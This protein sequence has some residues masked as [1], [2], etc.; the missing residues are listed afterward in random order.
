MKHSTT[1]RIANRNWRSVQCL[2]AP[3]RMFSV[4]VTE[5][6]SS[7]AVAQLL[8]A[9]SSAPKNI[10]CANSGTCCRIRLGRISCGSV[11]IRPRTI[12][13]SISVAE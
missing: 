7:V 9:E 1:A 3:R 2:N 8:I 12:F 6:A 10:T 5:G 13:G 11:S 4:K